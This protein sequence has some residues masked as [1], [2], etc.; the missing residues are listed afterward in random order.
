MSPSH[1][2]DDIILTPSFSIFGL[3]LCV[4]YLCVCVSEF[5]LTHFLAGTAARLRSPTSVQAGDP[6]NPSSHHPALLPLQ[7]HLGLGHPHP[8]LL[9]SHHGALQCLLQDQAE[10]RDLAGG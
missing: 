9:H 7:D 1:R 5:S 10:Q 8:H 2:Q 4:I 3:L 6:Q